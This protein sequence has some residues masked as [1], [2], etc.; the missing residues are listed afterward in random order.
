MNERLHFLDWLRV[1]AVGFV[2]LVHCLL[3]FA[4]G[5]WIVTDADAITFVAIL[6][7]VFNQ[8][9]IPL[10]F[11][12]SGAGVWYAL[13]SRTAR[14]F[15]QER[16]QRLIIPFIFGIIL[17]SPIQTYFH[18]RQDAEFDGTLFHH[19]LPQFF[20]ANHFTTRDFQWV[21]S[22]GYHLWFLFFLFAF[23][24]LSLSLFI[25]LRQRTHIIDFLVKMCQIKGSSLL[26]AIPLLIAQA[27]LRANF[28][29]Y[30]SWADFVFWLIYFIYGYILVS[31][32]RFIQ[33]IQRDL[34]YSFA[35]L[36]ISTL[37]IVVIYLRNEDK[38]AVQDVMD[39]YSNLMLFTL[40]VTMNSWASMLMLLAI[41]SRYL[42]WYQ[43]ILDRLN[44]NALP[45]YL[46]H[47]PPIVVIAF[48]V[49]RWQLASV[50]KFI[51][52]FGAS[53]VITIVSY[54]ML[55]KIF[56]FTRVWLGMRPINSNR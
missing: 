22:Y 2:F 1:I 6:I 56:P 27:L 5:S 34:K 55:I 36:I 13:R 33:A 26:F 25:Y 46:F 12:V 18:L 15:I 17:F 7:G 39:F 41:T 43:P 29:D 4:G 3:P 32:E 10:L 8:F 47:Q 14:Q 19:Y 50:L 16:F 20:R 37:M 54:Q 45:F 21:G 38:T 11:L 24:L 31:D 48:F 44:E 23:S 42:N 30:L 52:I 35:L 9:G 28:A 49:T 53:L 40:A 51:L